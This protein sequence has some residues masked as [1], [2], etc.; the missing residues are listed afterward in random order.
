M[1]FEEFSTDIDTL[2]LK[3][4]ILKNEKSIIQKY[5]AKTWDLKYDFDGETG[6]GY[7]SLTSRSCH[8]NVLEWWGTKKLKKTIKQNYKKLTN[9]RET[10]IYVQCWANVL[11]NGE[12][13]KPHLHSDEE[14]TRYF[15]LVSGNLFIY[16]DTSTSTY[17]GEKKVPNII[18]NMVLFSSCL[19]HSTDRYIGND[20]RVSIAFDIRDSF[21]ILDIHPKVRNHW[22]KI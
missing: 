11:R 8:F 13:V 10:S 18:G 7:E 15:N 9:S 16:S 12:M 19:K 4:K 21:S 14:S 6:L 1:F 17:Y 3:K 5:P 2:Y 22:K 20:C